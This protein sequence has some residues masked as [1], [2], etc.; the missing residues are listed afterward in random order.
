MGDS[1]LTSHD[2]Q[3]V[4][5]ADDGY[6]GE[7]HIPSIL[8][9]KQDGAALIEAVSKSMVTVQLSW[10][11]PQDH[12]VSMDLWMSA[13]SSESLQFL[14]DFSEKRKTLNDVMHFQPH[15]AVFSMASSDPAVYQ[16]LCSDTTG[17][18]CAEDPDTAGDI[19]GKDVLEEDV[20]QLC[21]HELTKKSRSMESSS[22]AP[23]VEYAEEYWNY[24]EQFESAC[25]L[26]G[27]GAHA[28]FGTECSEKLMKKVGLD[29]D[30]VRK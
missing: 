29:V 12:V 22:A 9:S 8:I 28:R 21:I 10:D 27:D 20:R 26:D 13:G 15:Y 14:K 18:F 16:G 23:A 24:V 2:L 30:A 17:N 4:I 25:P 5:V 7:I 19:T 1:D 6:G 3:N 11:V